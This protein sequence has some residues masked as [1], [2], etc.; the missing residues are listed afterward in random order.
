MDNTQKVLITAQALDAKGVQ[1]SFTAPPVFVVDNPALATLAA[2]SPTDPVPPAGQFSMWLL[3]VAGSVGTVNVSASENAV[4]GD[5]TT[6]LTGSLAVPITAP[7]PP[8]D[9]ATSVAIS[10]GSAIAQ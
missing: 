7:I 6:K 4:L 1:V 9:L 10:A 3:P 5:D 2:L 8:V